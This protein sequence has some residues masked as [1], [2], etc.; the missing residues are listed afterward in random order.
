MEASKLGKEKMVK[1]I[2]L[3]NSKTRSLDRKETL[4]QLASFHDLNET[5][6]TCQLH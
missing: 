6:Q 5:C 1:N 4:Y 3:E 2:D